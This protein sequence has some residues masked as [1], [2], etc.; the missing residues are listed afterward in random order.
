MIFLKT[1]VV[2]CWEETL[3][4]CKKMMPVALAAMA[5]TL[6][7]STA[8]SSAAMIASDNAANYS[9]GGWTGSSYGSGFGPWN[10]VANGNGG[11]AGTYLD[12]GYNGN[13]S[14]P[15]QSGSGNSNNGGGYAWATYA[16]SSNTA[17]IDLY[18]PF[19]PM[20]GGYSDP[21]GLGT[22]FNNTF[23]LDL[24]TGGIG[25][26]GQYFGFSLQTGQT[27]SATND[28]TFG[29]YGGTGYDGM[30]LTDNNGTN[31]NTGQ[32]NTYGAVNY[33]ALSGGIVVSVSVGNG[34]PD[35]LNP[36]TITATNVSGTTYFSYS[37][38][39]N[40]PLQQV[41]VFDNN[42]GGD[43]YFNDLSIVPEPGSLGML[44]L[45][46]IGLLIRR[47]KTA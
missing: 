1:W 31:I 21:S 5:G 12:E 8:I 23:S 45:G 44:A 14:A 29:Y 42:T 37:G 41:D 26:S 2:L 40:G 15:I 19:L 7:L 43:E 6:G 32:N 28:I 47:R 39:E 11:F 36:Y 24:L 20:A 25:G 30:T 33:S 10:I 38:S 3:M 16:N 22:L 34:N 18:R 46:A 13:V 9:G 17:R 27:P 35:G 4:F